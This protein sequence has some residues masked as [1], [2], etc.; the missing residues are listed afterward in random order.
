[1]TNII[2]LI[3]CSLCGYACG[4]YLEKRVRNK[5]AFLTDLC[6]YASFLKVNVEGRCIELSKFNSEFASSCSEV[7]RDYLISGKLKCALTSTQKESVSNF[8]S[9]LDCASS[10]ELT[11]HLDH[12][13]AVFDDMSKQFTQKEL[14]SSSM[15]SKLGVL[16]GV[17]LGI[18]L[19]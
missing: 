13:V 6:R 11:K 4:K 17:M 15:Y 8:F 2:I 1:M 10:Q 7:F 3:T 19:M 14:S 9:N 16:L 18:V 5:G 12:Y